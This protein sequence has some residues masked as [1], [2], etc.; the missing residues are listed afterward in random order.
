M[1][2][3]IFVQP[4]L[5]F[6]G[7][8]R[9]TVIVANA[10]VSRGHEVDVV[11]FGS[12]GGLAADL[13]ERI[14]LHV[15]GIE[16]HVR[17]L[18]VAFRLERILADLPP[19]LVIVK[20]WSAV[21][22]CA[23]IDRRARAVR[24]TFVYCEDLDPTAHHE[25][26]PLGRLKRHVVGAVF[27]SRQ[28]VVAN[29]SPVAERMQRT[30]R[31]ARRPVV[32]PV[33]VDPALRDEPLLDR[34]A[35]QTGRAEV[36][37]V[38][39]LVPLKGLDVTLAALRTL[40]RPVR[41]TVVGDGPLAA[42]LAGFHDPTGRLTVRLTGGVRDPHRFVR[43]AD[44]LVHSSRSEAW[45][46]VVLEALAIGTPVVASDTIGPVEMRSRLGARPDLLEL[47]PVGGVGDLAR[48]LQTRLDGPRPTPEDCAAYVAPFGVDTAVVQW[49][50][51]SAAWAEV[52]R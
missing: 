22:T 9:Q 43:E 52:S 4:H 31:L 3:F 13:D 23:L 5:R 46:A 48:I 12:G 36:V 33:V 18:Q 24:H 41:W 42:E 26:I 1:S 45:G 2:R 40:D 25:F 30:Y 27:R 50:Q 17:T 38:G 51:R 8:E 10:L 16:R 44:L 21:L 11:L 28:Y 14:G 19:A 7:A 6:G 20:L 15:L 32:T 37:S 39:S 49:E 35:R 34:A 29:S 47:Y